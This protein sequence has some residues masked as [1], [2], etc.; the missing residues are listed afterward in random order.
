MIYEDDNYI[1]KYSEIDKDYI[2]DIILS[3]NLNSK[4]IMDFFKL[5]KLSNK[6]NIVIWDSISSYRNQLEPRL[7]KNGRKYHEWMIGDTF[8]GSINMMTISE[9]RKTKDRGNYS[10]EEFLD[11]ISHEFVHICQKEAKLTNLPSWVW[12]MLATNL[13]NPKK[14][15]NIDVS[16]EELTNNFDNIKG[17][18]SMAFTIGNY[19][20]QNYGSDYV[21]YF[22]KNYNS[23]KEL[24]EQ[25][26]TE[27]K[28]WS[29]DKEKKK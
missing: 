23:K 1:I 6:V 11:C 3:L 26:F 15:T 9:V 18:Y 12:E 10:I 16:L 4:R 22:L 2:Q 8:S 13:G 28:E 19:L 14:V 21:L 5:E 20:F 29:N 7:I 17:N 24:V 27:A 25:I